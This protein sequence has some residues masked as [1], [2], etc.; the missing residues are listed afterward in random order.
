MYDKIFS[1]TGNRWNV[2]NVEYLS[3]ERGRNLNSNDKKASLCEIVPMTPITLIN[4]LEVKKA[5]V[6]HHATKIYLELVFVQDK[7]VEG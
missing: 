4:H 2:E 3:E 7:T 5:C 1:D 6:F